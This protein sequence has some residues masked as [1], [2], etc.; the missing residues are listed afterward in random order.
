LRERKPKVLAILGKYDKSFIRLGA[1]ASKKD[2]EDTEV[3]FFDAGHSDLEKGGEVAEH[4][5]SFL[6]HVDWKCVFASL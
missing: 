3:R 6:A 5:I 4:M 2:I 1:E